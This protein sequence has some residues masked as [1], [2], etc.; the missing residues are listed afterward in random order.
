VIFSI[1]LFVEDEHMSRRKFL[2]DPGLTPMG[3]RVSDDIGPQNLE[4]LG[5][6]F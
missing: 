6:K 1:V 5:S 3:C 2:W 4:D